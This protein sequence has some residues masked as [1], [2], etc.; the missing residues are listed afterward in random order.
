MSRDQQPEW[1]GRG[2]ADIVRELT[3]PGGTV[4]ASTSFTVCTVDGAEARPGQYRRL[5]EQKTVDRLCR[6]ISS[7]DN[8]A[9]SRHS[10]L[11]EASAW[12]TVHMTKAYAHLRYSLS[13]R[14]ALFSQRF[15][16]TTPGPPVFPGVLCFLP[17]G[18]RSCT[19]NRPRGA[20]SCNIVC[21]YPA[22]ACRQLRNKR[23]NG[24]PR[25]VI[26]I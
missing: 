25:C 19:S 16:H 17:S 22:A 13:L 4:P 6:R 2:A 9:F 5:R 8:S 20:S 18:Q 7:P 26:I 21:V 12:Q 15:L 11:W 23:F 3:V 24:V 10:G 1:S 14:K